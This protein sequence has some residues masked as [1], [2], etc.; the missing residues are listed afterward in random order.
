MP[1]IVLF[2]AVTPTPGY[3]IEGKIV[4]VM[5][6]APPI[7]E[8]DV[9]AT[10]PTG[11]IPQIVTRSDVR[12]EIPVQESEAWAVDL[13]YGGNTLFYVEDVQTAF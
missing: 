2:S 12:L 10:P 7:Y 8:I 13:R 9:I 1:M 6:T 11:I 5:E 4:S 3:S